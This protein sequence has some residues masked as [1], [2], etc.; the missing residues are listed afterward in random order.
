MTPSTLDAI[1]DRLI[2][3]ITEA[4]ARGAMEAA[5]F[6]RTVTRVAAAPD[7][8]ALA[9]EASAFGRSMGI[10]I[11]APLENR[12]ASPPRPP[13]PAG[14]GEVVELSCVGGDLREEGDWVRSGAYRISLKSSNGRLD[15][16]EYEGE[17][18]FRLLLELDLVSSNLKL[19]VPEGFEVEDRISERR[20]STFRDRPEGGI[21]D[22]CVVTLT[23]SLRSS[24]LR[25]RR[26]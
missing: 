8:E 21:Y 20:S 15:L 17:P 5:D 4:Y 13:I 16:R 23:G 7:A 14:G 18:G 6:E 3:G 9:A 26:R 24:N 25:V 10:E 2:E 11:P 19:I 12:G 22:G 1:K